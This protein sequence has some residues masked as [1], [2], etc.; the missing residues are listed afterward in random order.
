MTYIS[1]HYCVCER[2]LPVTVIP[3]RRRWRRHLSTA[4]LLAPT[5]AFALLALGFVFFALLLHL[6]PLLSPTRVAFFAL[7]RPLYL[8]LLLLLPVKRLALGVVPA[9]AQSCRHFGQLSFFGRRKSMGIRWFEGL[10]RRWRRQ[11]SE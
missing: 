9:C 7:R 6:F 3:R 2:H 5:K 1:K 4:V 10:G 11:H 8:H